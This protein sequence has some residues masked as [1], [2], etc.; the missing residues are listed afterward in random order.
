MATPCSVL[1]WEIPL[2]GEPGGLQVTASRGA[3]QTA[4]GQE[5]P[6]ETALGTVTQARQPGWGAADGRTNALG[7]VA[8]A[9]QP[10]WGAADGWRR[11]ETGPSRASDK[12]PRVP[13]GL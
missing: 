12:C 3:G 1:A 2:T 6:P 8:Q 9:R 10:G 7:T 5:Q 13:R 4:A 11:A